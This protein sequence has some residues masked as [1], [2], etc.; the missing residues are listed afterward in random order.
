[1]KNLKNIKI[2]EEYEEY[3]RIMK[4]LEKISDHFFCEFGAY[5]KNIEDF[6]RILKFWSIFE[7]F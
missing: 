1:M 7:D 6:T 5:L 2:F 3:L 4:I